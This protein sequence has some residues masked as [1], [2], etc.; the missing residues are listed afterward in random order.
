MTAPHL[1]MSFLLDYK[2]KEDVCVGAAL[3]RMMV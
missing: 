2:R 3:D 1:S